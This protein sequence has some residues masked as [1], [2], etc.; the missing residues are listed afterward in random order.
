MANFRKNPP[1]VRLFG[2]NGLIS[3]V[4]KFIDSD[5]QEQS[6]LVTDSSKHFEKPSPP[7]EVFSLKN[8]VE[9]GVALKEEN[10]VVFKSDSLTDSELQKINEVLDA[11]PEDE[12]DVEP[13]VDN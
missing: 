9:S 8:K 10:S 1:K 4:E 13:D 3:R 7:P 12:S 6:V 2:G 5:L 11:K